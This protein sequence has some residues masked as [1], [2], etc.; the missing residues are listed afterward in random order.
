MCWNSGVRKRL[1][2]CSMMKT[3][4][5][6][7]LRREHSTYQG[8]AVRQ[9]LAMATGWRQRKASRQR[10]VKTAQMRTAPP[11]RMIA[12]GPFARTA[13]PRKNPKKIRARQGGRGRIGECSLRVRTRVEAANT[14]ATE[15]MEEKGKCVA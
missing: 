8:S 13:K 15:S 4:K 9:K 11:E 12:A 7:G 10:L 6:S 5:N 2:L 14:R 3:R 1:K